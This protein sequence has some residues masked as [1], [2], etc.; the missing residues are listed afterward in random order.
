MLLSIIRTLLLMLT[1]AAFAHADNPAKRTIASLKAEI[2]QLRAKE[3]A[4]VK[5]IDGRYK[6]LITELEKT[7]VKEAELRTSL[8]KEEKLVLEGVKDKAEREQIKAR[9]A[10]MI[11]ALTGDI[12][13]RKEVI[14]EL[15]TE[16]TLLTKRIKANYTALID[17]LEQELKALEAN[18][19]SKTK[20]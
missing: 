18:S 20:G 12:K 16:K 7:D 4:D 14:K 6:T 17:K 2:K 8:R 1:L 15:K 19:S 5:A 11:N 3:K 9:F 13:G 10:K